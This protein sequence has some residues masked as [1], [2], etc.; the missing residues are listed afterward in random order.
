PTEASA[1]ALP[2]APIDAGFA[3]E[4]PCA[5]GWVGVASDRGSTTPVRAYGGVQFTLS[6]KNR[7]LG[8]ETT[9]TVPPK[10]P[11]SG[12][13]FLW[14]GLQ[15]LPG[16]AN[17]TPINNGVLQSVLT[18]GKTCAPNAPLDPYASWW[19]SAQYVNTFGIEPGYTGCQG[20]E[21]IDVAVG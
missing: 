3:G 16:S 5:G 15:P 8:L 18:W 2:D 13:L 4:D 1:D 11:A 7:I 14:P 19:I 12:T 9:L 20:G 21:G 10:P 6:T 17:F